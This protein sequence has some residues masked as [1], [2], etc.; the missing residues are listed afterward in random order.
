MRMIIEQVLCLL[1][2]G[3]NFFLGLPESSDN[4]S[5]IEFN[6]HRVYGYKSLNLLFD[7]W[8]K[9][10]EIKS[11]DGGHSIFVLKKILYRQVKS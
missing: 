11:R 10:D 1:K 7:G 8:T 5:Y 3:G 6:A 9:V 2:P 4:S